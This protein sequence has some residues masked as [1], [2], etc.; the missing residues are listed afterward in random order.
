MPSPNTVGMK[1]L[2]VNAPSGFSVW[3]KYQSQPE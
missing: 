1:G 3:P 2:T